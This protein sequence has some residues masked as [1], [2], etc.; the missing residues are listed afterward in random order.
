MTLTETLETAKNS[1]LVSAYNECGGNANRMAAY[2]GVRQGQVYRMLRRAGL[3]AVRP[4]VSARE[5]MRPGGAAPVPTDAPNAEVL[6]AE[7]RR[8]T[9]GQRPYWATP[10]QRQLIADGRAQVVRVGQA[11]YLRLVRGQAAVAW[12]RQ[13]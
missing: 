10:A 6:A 2:L 12:P 5:P 3:R 11:Y 7:V 8:L 9:E 4:T 1:A 13:P